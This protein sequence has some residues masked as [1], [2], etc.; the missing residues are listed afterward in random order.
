MYVVYDNNKTTLA[1]S[2]LKREVS[3]RERQN[4]EAFQYLRL[5][6]ILRNKFVSLDMIAR[7][8]LF[9]T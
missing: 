6:D 3:S 8:S 4:P 7:W 5:I 9:F 1:K 2:S